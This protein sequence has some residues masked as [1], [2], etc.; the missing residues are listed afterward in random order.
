M[1]CEID[2]GLRNLSVWFFLLLSIRPTIRRDWIDSEFIA[3]ALNISFPPLLAG[4]ARAGGGNMPSS[5]L[6]IVE[7]QLFNLPRE[8]ELQAWSNDGRGEE[9]SWSM[10]DYDNLNGEKQRASIFLYHVTNEACWFTSRLD[11][12]RWFVLMISRR[13]EMQMLAV[14]EAMRN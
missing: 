14:G 4:W 11:G 1:L 6:C 7:W 13:F 9:K 2:I 12:H 8:R 10:T 3:H 5:R